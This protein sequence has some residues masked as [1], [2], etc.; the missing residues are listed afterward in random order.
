ME[1]KYDE[2]DSRS[3]NCVL[4]N[5]DGLLVQIIVCPIAIA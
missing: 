4:S 1:V 3:Q 5:Y 2:K